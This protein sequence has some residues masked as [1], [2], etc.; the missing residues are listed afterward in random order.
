MP[1]H[2]LLWTTGVDG[3]RAHVANLFSIVVEL[4]HF[5]HVFSVRQL[6]LHFLRVHELRLEHA[7]LHVQ[8]VLDRV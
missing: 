8:F 2:L 4:E 3:Q 5:E 7:S 1:I 6:V